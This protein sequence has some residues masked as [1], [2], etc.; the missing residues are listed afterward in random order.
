MKRSVRLAVSV[1][2]GLAAFLLAG[3]YGDA[4]RTEAS[5]TRAEALAA[6]GGEIVSVCVATRDIEPG[7]LLDE[8]NVA[9]E[10]WI[11]YLLPQNA[12]TDPGDVMGDSATSS[13]PAR[14]VISPVYLEE[15]GDAIEVPRGRV[16]V[17]VATDSESAVGGAIAPGDAVDVYVSDA[18]VADRLCQARVIDT[19]AHR[20][21]SEPVQ[22]AS[23]AWVT[24]AVEP[25]R[26]S[27]LLAAT[28]SGR[29]SLT[30]PAPSSDRSALRDGEPGE[31][32][33][34]ASSGEES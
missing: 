34:E 14:A 30:L 7:E 22:G 31:G 33:A 4:V 19:S 20:G 8:S 24:L 21:G 15:R 23:I 26:V 6:Y 11:G 1:A 13:I 2:S 32:A 16:A 12:V 9:V 17:S 5:E 18:G 29:I 3:A 28:A 27:E 25:E 10:D